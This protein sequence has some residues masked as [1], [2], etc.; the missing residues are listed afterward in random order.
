MPARPSIFTFWPV[1]SVLIRPLIPTIVGIPISR[2]TTAE[3]ERMLP[4]STRMPETAGKRGTHQD[5][6]APRR[7]FRPRDSRDSLGHTAPEPNRLPRQ[8]NNDPPHIPS[9]D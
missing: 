4:R 7:G 9:V 3:C 8:D 2:A 5:R 1:L 6:F